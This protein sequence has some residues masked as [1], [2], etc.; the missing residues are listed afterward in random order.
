M[1]CFFHA[2]YNVII[3]SDSMDERIND[4]HLRLIK[5][6][7]EHENEEVTFEQFSKEFSYEEIL[8]FVKADP[9]APIL[10]KYVYPMEKT[11]ESE[12][13]R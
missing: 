5:F 10:T 8:D 4:I 7:R 12:R 3:I 9:L 2:W 11:K 13:Q 1:T 6:F